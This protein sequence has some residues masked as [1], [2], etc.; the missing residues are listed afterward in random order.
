[1]L[2]PKAALIVETEIIISLSMQA[3][4]QGHGIEEVTV[5][6]S[7]RDF[8][9]RHLSWDDFAFAILELERDKPDQIALIRAALEHGVPVLGLT[10]DDR[11]ADGMPEFPGMPIL[12]K[13]VPDQTLIEAV[14]A[15][16][17]IRRD[18]NE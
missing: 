11:L 7:P 8:G 5:L 6:T 9:R 12:V 13:P 14:S 1:M 3:A 18:Q 15:L 16:P 10:A 4:L 17:S 2:A